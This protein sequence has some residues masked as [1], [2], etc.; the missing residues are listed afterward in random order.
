MI[1]SDGTTD[2]PLSDSLRWTDEHA[3]SAVAAVDSRG[4][5]GAMT[6]QTS[7]KTAGRPITLAPSD[8]ATGLV[9]YALVRTL[10]AWTDD[11]AKSLTL[12]FPNGDSF[13][14]RF[15]YDGGSPLDA[16]PALGFTN[17]DEGEYWR[18]TLKLITT[19]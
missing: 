12:T 5:S 2:L 7:L 14:C 9:R 10:R 1:L 11:P 6:R 3:W 13:A 15:R 16:E 17:R 8:N 19:A 18:L 4:I